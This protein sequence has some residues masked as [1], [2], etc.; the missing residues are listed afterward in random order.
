MNP[1]HTHSSRYS[2]RLLLVGAAL[3]LLWAA[4][5]LADDQPILAT[6]ADA[7]ITHGPAS[8]VWAIGNSNIELIVGFDSSR[9]LV[10]EQ[11]WNPA[12]GHTLDVDQAPDAGITLGGQPLVLQQSDKLTFTGATAEDTGTGVR[13][14]FA[15]EQKST[16][17]TVK[18]VYVCYPATPTFEVWTRL[19]AGTGSTPLQVSDL[20]GWQLTI[21][22]G[23]VQWINGLRR[24][25]A[26]EWD[27]GS[28]S[29]DG[30]DLDDGQQ[31]AIGSTGRSAESF[32][33]LI[34]VDDGQ[35]NFYGGV[36]WSGSWQ[37]SLTKTGDRLSVRAGF[38]DTIT[39]LS[40]AHPV[41]LPHTFFGYTDHSRASQSV[42]LR[43]FMVG[44][45]RQGRPFAPL[46]TYNT[47]FPYGSNITEDQI[48]D[49]MRR[50]AAIGVELF[51][52]D[53]GWWVGA[54]AEGQGDF[55]SALGSW[56][57]DS[58]RF[59]DGLESLSNLAHDLGMKFGL[60][61]EP[62]RIALSTAGLPGMARES[63]L[64]MVD[65]S[66]TGD[67]TSAQLCLSASAARKWVFTKLVNLIETAHPDYLK[68]DTNFWI[69]CNRSGHDH[70]HDDGSFAHVQALYG[71]LDELRRR[72]PDLE[73][74]NVGWRLDYGMAAY[75]DSIWMDDRSAPSTHVRHNLEGIS[76]AFP[77]AYLLSFV[78]D[79]IDESLFT[80]DLP[81][82]MRSRMPGV[83]GLTYR[84]ADMDDDVMAGFANEIAKYK[85][86]RDIVARSS[87]TLLSDQAPVDSDG[88]DVVQEVSDDRQSAVVFAFKSDWNAGATTVYPQNLN[89]DVL[90]QAQSLDVGDLGT[91][92]G[93]DLMQSGVQI[94]QADSGTS[95]H[96]IVFTAAQ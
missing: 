46:V 89:P 34:F 73:I 85:Q 4:R 92:T 3:V 50:A 25:S 29:L 79:N 21:P 10:V 14:T 37:M 88:W 80:G 90:Y 78:I 7:Y 56:T 6:H 67:G 39:S 59:P 15:F 43:Q 16:H 69:N 48:A 32:V 40:T 63:W 86:I 83:L 20:A 68:W 95:A 17:T 52:V 22:S 31:V 19:E 9:T 12:T 77:P 74:E 51:V 82:I 41:E 94:V 96:V 70:G 57:V 28:Y 45:I 26:A 84:F 53:A 87:A 11:L 13:L 93:A 91:A 75:T 47:W 42:A 60:W 66:Y 55:S 8:Q 23:T 33:P 2:Y 54:G 24:D 44:G 71:L 38:P 49:E 30:G 18:R 64:A 81:A 27:P 36:I 58:D 72:Y 61:V 1:M 62:E 35:D 5:P 65:G 76:L